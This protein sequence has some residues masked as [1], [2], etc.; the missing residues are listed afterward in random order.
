[1]DAAAL[2]ATLHHFPSSPLLCV[3][4]A[5]ALGALHNLCQLSRSR[6]EQAAV[7]GAPAVLCVIATASPLYHSGV[8]VR[9]AAL[10]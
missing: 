2:A 9:C 6:Q 1:M 10:R 7:A 4:Q 3:L 8:Q 5:E